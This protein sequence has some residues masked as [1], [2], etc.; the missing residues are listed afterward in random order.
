M[1]TLRESLIKNGNN[2]SDEEL[3]PLYCVS[4]SEEEALEAFKYLQICRI[5]DYYVEKKDNKES[6]NCIG[7]STNGNKASNYFFQ[8]FRLKTP[9]KGKG[10]YT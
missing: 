10:N 7:I 3:E 4:I 1:D 6:E 9:T 8:R 2:V 5:G